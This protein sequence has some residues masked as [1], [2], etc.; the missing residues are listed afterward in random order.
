ML[1][2]KRNPSTSYLPSTWPTPFNKGLQWRM[3]VTVLFYFTRTPKRSGLAVERLTCNHYVVGSIS[4]EAI[5][6]LIFLQ[7]IFSH[8]CAVL[9]QIAELLAA[10]S[11]RSYWMLWFIKIYV[12]RSIC[13]F[14]FPNVVVAHILGKVN[15]CCVIFLRVYSRT[16]LLIFIEIG[17]YLTVTGQKMARF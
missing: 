9:L 8:G 10:S 2:G 7:I 3:A 12:N 16:T 6:P 14:K 11:V 17:S 4:T 1:V 13:R 15:T 5:Q